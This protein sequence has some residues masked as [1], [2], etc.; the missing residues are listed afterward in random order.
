MSQPGAKPNTGEAPKETPF[1]LPPRTAIAGVLASDWALGT[2]EAF[3]RQKE[4]FLQG[5]M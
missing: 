5:K 1:R 4:D 3:A 2:V